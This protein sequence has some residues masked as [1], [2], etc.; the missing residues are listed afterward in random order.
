MSDKQIVSTSVER[1]APD[2]G[3][4]IGFLYPY[5]H[6]ATVVTSDGTVTTG[7]GVSEA[8][9]LENATERALR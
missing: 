5:T 1:F 7:K 4:I 2:P 6:E 8:G 3:V 9:A